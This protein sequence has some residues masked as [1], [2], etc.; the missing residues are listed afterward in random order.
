MYVK[1]NMSDKLVEILLSASGKIFT[2]KKCIILNAAFSPGIT[3]KQ[4]LLS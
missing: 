1:N 3:G 4:T 2:G